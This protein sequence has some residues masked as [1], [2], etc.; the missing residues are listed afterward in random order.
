MAPY[1]ST[2]QI[3]WIT[4]PPGHTPDP[5]H[6]DLIALEC[7]RPDWSAAQAYALERDHRAVI[8]Q[9]ID[10]RRDQPHRGTVVIGRTQWREELAVE[11]IAVRAPGCGAEVRAMAEYMGRQWGARFIIGCSDRKFCR[12]F[13]A[14]EFARLFFLKIGESKL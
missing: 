13:G 2:Q 9:A 11:I 6:A 8:L 12:A 7:Q 1:H 5:V 3:T 14:T 4:C 10:A